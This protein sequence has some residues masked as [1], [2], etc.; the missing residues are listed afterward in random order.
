MS[1]EH[2]AIRL[3]LT[4]R[5]PQR[6]LR[7]LG[8]HGSYGA[9]FIIEVGCKLWSQLRPCATTI[10]LTINAIT[11]SSHSNRCLVSEPSVVVGAHRLRRTTVSRSSC[12]P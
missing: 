7:E 1:A 8:V 10:E 5:E 2:L 12:G 11:G 6:A 3:G 4:Q 9:A